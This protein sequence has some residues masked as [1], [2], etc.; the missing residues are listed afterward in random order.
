MLDIDRIL[1]PTDLTDQAERAFSHAA[2]LAAWHDADLHTLNIVEEGAGNSSSA[3]ASFPVPQD[4][5]S[6]LLR[7]KEDPPQ[8]IDLGALT[9]VQE[10]KQAKSP[11]EGIVAYADSHDIDL[12]VMG[13]HGRRGLR[14]LLLGSVAEEVLRR[15]HCPVLTLRGQGD[16]PP[17]WE[18][19]NILTPVDFSDASMEALHHAKE[20]AV[21][22]EAQLTLLHAVEEVIYPSAYG[23]DM[24]L[25]GPEVVEQVE[26]HLV[27][28]ARDEIG[29]E[30]V[31]VEASVGYAPSSIL[32]YTE[33]NDVDL[34]TI[35]THGRTGLERMLLG[36]VT[37]RVVRQAA[38]PVLVA[39]S[40]GKSLSP[41]SPDSSS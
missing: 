11:P 17:A 36:S 26:E 19:R 1:W 23:L 16:T 28:I 14:R 41:T 2:T 27:R 31:A 25:P 10:Q 8:S 37:E 12:V 20:L 9:L 4:T 22:Y 32:E 40:F 13:T 3:G 7:K 33:T 35:A 38:A 30:D 6:S 5:L 39:K 15:A 29:Y 24:N 34:V 21:T 18:V